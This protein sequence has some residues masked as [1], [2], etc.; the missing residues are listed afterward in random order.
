MIDKLSGHEVTS[1]LSPGLVAL[2]GPEKLGEIYA[3]LLTVSTTVLTESTGYVHNVALRWSMLLEHRLHWITSL[4]LLSTSNASPATGTLANIFYFITLGVCYTASSQLFISTV[5]RVE[6]LYNNPTP[7]DLR[8]LVNGTALLALGISLLIQAAIVTRMLWTTKSWIK[9]WSSNPLSITLACAHETMSQ[10][11]EERARYSTV[12]SAAYR[13]SHP[14]GSH[15]YDQLQHSKTTRPRR[16][17]KSLLAT[18]KKAVGFS[19]CNISALCVGV[20]VWAIV[21]FLAWHVSR[22][23]DSEAEFSGENKKLKYLENYI[24]QEGPWRDIPSIQFWHAETTDET[25]STSFGT[26]GAAY[27]LVVFAMQSYLTFVLH[28]TEV[29]VNSNRDERYWER[30]AAHLKIA[31]SSEQQVKYRQPIWTA[32]SAKV[33]GAPL[34]PPLIISSMINPPDPFLLA[35]KSLA[36]WLFN[37]ALLPVYFVLTRPAKNT[38]WKGEGVNI[39]LFGLPTV[40]LA[41]VSLVLAVYAIFVAFRKPKGPQPSAY[42]HIPTLLALIDDWGNGDQLY[43]GD[44][45]TGNN[46]VRCAGTASNLSGV[47]AIDMEAEYT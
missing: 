35:A 45:G 6:T 8:S 25:F 4:R 30:A 39:F 23:P 24:L 19:L 28:C 2:N 16:K 12:T 9:T 32:L 38:K 31:G 15:T 10:G 36:H 43:W 27:L 11:A 17:Q 41:A 33:N 22:T 7:S 18:R 46:G 21:V 1:Q 3:L 29:L 13:L 26:M 20:S 47:G 44:K 37:R 5:F 40:A 14:S 34:N 42:G